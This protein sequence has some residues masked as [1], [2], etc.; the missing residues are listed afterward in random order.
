M[1]GKPAA[2]IGDRVA[3][4][5]RHIVLVTSPTGPVPTMMG[6]PYTAVITGGGCPQVLIGGSPAATV[7][8][9]VALQPPHIPPPNT[10][11]QIPPTNTGTTTMGSGSVLIGGRP[12][13]RAQDKVLTC[14][15][16]VP[17]ENGT[18]QPPLRNH[19]VLIG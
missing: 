2:R 15:D 11:F 10:V 12:A 1:P 3:G 6:F 7:G 14:S 19:Q 17:S 4:T 8:S 18:V 5:D 13:V 16:P 9:T